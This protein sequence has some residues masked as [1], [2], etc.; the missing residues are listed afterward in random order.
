MENFVVKEINSRKMVIKKANSRSKIVCFKQSIEDNGVFKFSIIDC[1]K[2][3]YTVDY[4]CE[5]Q[6]FSK[7]ATVVDIREIS[8]EEGH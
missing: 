1:M 3:F 4:Q 2:N 7:F 8:S 5:Y 6:S